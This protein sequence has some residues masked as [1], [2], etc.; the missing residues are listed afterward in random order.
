MSEQE[1]S[2]GM[3]DSTAPEV[4]AD[5]ATGEIIKEGAPPENLQAPPVEE[6]KSEDPLATPKEMIK[7]EA[8][9]DPM[10]DFNKGPD[11]VGNQAIDNAG[12]PEVEDEVYNMDEVD[13]NAP[14]FEPLPTGWYKHV[15]T[16]Q[17]WG[18]SKKKDP[19]MTTELTVIDETK[20]Q[21][22]GRRISQYALFKFNNSFT[23]PV[24]EMGRKRFKV[25]MIRAGIPIEWKTFKPKEFAASGKALGHEI[26]L[27]LG[28]GDPYEN[29][30]G[31]QQ[32]N[33]TIKEIKTA[34][35]GG[36][37]LSDPV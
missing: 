8:P 37:F 1:K 9:P 28:L 31:Q 13:E 17:K 10:A 25:L 12:E 3:E 15:I 16:N 20:P 21:Y 22:K 33:N 32:R 36:A 23:D 29:S 18:K 7:E 11:Q 5:P 30:E 35:A 4:K 34:G 26:Y 6:V 24:A 2:V 19:M 14:D 27:K